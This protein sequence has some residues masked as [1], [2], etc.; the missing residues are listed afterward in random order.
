M[1]RIIL[2]GNGFDLAHGMKTSYKDFIDDFWEQKTEKVIEK[3]I[4]DAKPSEFENYNVGFVY[5]DNDIRITDIRIIPNYNEKPNIEKRGYERLLCFILSINGET[6]RN[7][8][9]TNGFLEHITKKS[10]RHWVDI[11]NEYYSL[12]YEC[13]NNK[14]GDIDK[15]NNEFS[16]LQVSLEN[17]LKSLDISKVIKYHQVE[18]KISTYFPPY[19]TVAEIPAGVGLDNFLYLN[20]NYTNTEKLYTYPANKIIHIHGELDNPNN[21]IIFGYGDDT[22]EKYKLIEQKNDNRFLKNMKSIKYAATR[23]YKEMLNFIKLDKYQVYIM[24]HSCGISDKTL[25]NTLFEHEN[26]LSIKVFYHNRGDG[27][28]NHN[29][30]VSNISRNFTKKS[31]FRERIV[32]KEDSEPL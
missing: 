29:D 30:V 31:L 8:T 17:Y 13:S 5:I 21:P 11:E 27:T 19:D 9:V 25:L 24:G 28:D 16:M 15:L 14:R 32:P 20:F 6:L 3:F 12:L 22:D 23:N 1:N 26:C 10:Q 18:Q 2:I 7:L 4:N